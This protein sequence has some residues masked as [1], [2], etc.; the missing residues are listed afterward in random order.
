LWF[1]RTI[2]K[3][4][5]DTYEAAFEIVLR[6]HKAENIT[7][8]IMEPVPGDW[9]VLSASHKALKASSSQLEMN[10]PVPKDGETV[11]TYRVRMRF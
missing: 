5:S 8:R 11:V 6:N 4:A 2:S 10:V 7:V 9:Q 3:I 1:R